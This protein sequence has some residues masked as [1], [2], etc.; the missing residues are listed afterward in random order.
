[1]LVYISNAFL[2]CSF[3]CLN[4]H[5]PIGDASLAENEPI[6]EHEIIK[7]IKKQLTTMPDMPVPF[8]DD[9]SAA[10]LLGGG[11]A[12]LKTDMLVASTDV[13]P[14][15]SL[16]QAARKA[17]VMNISDFA[18]KG[19]MPTAAIVAL[20]LPK[21]LANKKAV[22]EIAQG[23][24]DGARE[25]GA[26]IIGGDTNE[27]S[28][29][30]ISISLYGSAQNALMLRKGARTGDIVAVT[31]PF[32]KTAAGL[33]MLLGNCK[34]TEKVREA[35]LD[36]VYHPN[37]RLREGLALRGYDF[38][39]SSMDSSD[40][41]AWS[42]HE[43]AQNSKIGFNIDKLPI[44]PEVQEFAHQNDLDEADLVFYGGEEYELVLT[45]KP[46]KWEEAKNVIE[47]VHGHL[48][49]IGKATYDKSVVYESKGKKRV[50]EPRGW[51]HFK[52]QI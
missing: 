33:K 25:Y 50:I 36:A 23:L 48:I 47:T 17:V 6:G 32:G 38:V 27:T 4:I 29:L 20:G 24:N 28:D 12:V 35:L 22:T 7:L 49:P 30:I 10:P 1:M 34:A 46:D 5:L 37:A 41:L 52:S 14:G 43:L 16:Y 44:A 45:I 3:I 13:P 51:E 42:L 39:T 15:M 21:H 31:G 26:Y 18:S 19:A 11:M 9:V 40:G 8:G 2:G